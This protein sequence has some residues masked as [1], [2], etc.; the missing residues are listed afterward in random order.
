MPRVKRLMRGLPADLP[1]KASSGSTIPTLPTPPAK[2]PTVRENTPISPDAGSQ[3]TQPTQYSASLSAADAEQPSASRLSTQALFEALCRG[4]V[5]P[6]LVRHDRHHYE[7]CRLENFGGDP[8]NALSPARVEVLYDEP[9]VVLLHSVLSPTEIE[10]LR[11]IG[12]PLVS[13]ILM[14]FKR[15]VCSL[16]T[17]KKAVN[18]LL[19][20]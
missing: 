11:A 9:Y 2:F 6:E 15:I 7:S 12:T 3:S 17:R 5:F 18:Y 19:V 1:T 20:S 4:T 8:A 14:F 10:Q 16:H 13:V